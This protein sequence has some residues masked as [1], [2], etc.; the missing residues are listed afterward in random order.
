MRPAAF[1]SPL[2]IVILVGLLLA[3]P[4]FLFGFPTSTI[5][6][7]IHIRWA[8]H[9]AAQFWSGSIYPRYFPELNSNFGSPSFFYYPPLST[10]LSVLIWPIAPE[11]GRAWYALGW[12]AAVGLVLSSV[13]MWLFL[14]HCLGRPWFAVLGAFMYVIAPYH[15]GI[16]LLSRGA[17]AEFWAFALMPLVLLSFGHL[18]DEKQNGNLDRQTSLKKGTL[19]FGL[20]HAV[21]SQQIILTAFS[22]AALFCCHVLTAIMF[23]PIALGY[24]LLLGRFTFFRAI[25]AGL[26]SLLLS[27]IYLL[28]AVMYSAYIAGHDDA[29]FMGEHFRTTFFFPN[30][31]LRM[32][33]HVNDEFHQGLFV[34]FVGQ[35]VILAMC[36]ISLLFGKALNDKRRLMILFIILLQFCIAMML[37]ISEQIYEVIPAF[38]RLQFAWRF[39]SPA[40]FLS[41][42]MIGILAI[43]KG[44]VSALDRLVLGIAVGAWISTSLFVNEQLY[45]LNYSSETSNW[46]GRPPAIEL[47][48]LDAF[49][50]YVPSGENL[51]SAQK[52]FEFS[53]N[54]TPFSFVVLSGDGRVAIEPHT[55]RWLKIE[56]DSKSGL[57]LLVHQFWFPGW[58]ARD[59]ASGKPIAVTRHRQSGLI[60]L[61][62]P[63]G[64][65][66]LDLRLTMLW[67]ETIGLVTS[68]V[69]ASLLLGILVWLRT[70]MSYC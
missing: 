31:Q 63:E 65:K 52:V 17:N 47:D 2:S 22:L 40:T 44:R 48:S 56:T 30:L 15:V 13:A 51:T 58:M 18:A 42:A 35:I 54:S 4:L 53:T 14:R 36:I 12:S 27:A 5:D 32:P 10:F 34:V 41:S 16:D 25:T 7:P 37:P 9:S 29:F 50:E 38:Q 1:L 68:I 21:P 45:R 60:Q 67:P 3:L 59:A 62:I 8:H 64:H 46:R 55:A 61:V 57:S 43:S 20:S 19:R 28:P 33:L 70:R 39:L 66:N 26:W 23:A 6:G 49:G 11:Q 69:S 24:A